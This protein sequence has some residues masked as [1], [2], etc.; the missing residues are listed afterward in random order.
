MRFVPVALADRPS[1]ARRGHPVH[2]RRHFIDLHGP[3][4]WQSLLHGHHVE[5][6][7]IEVAIPACRVVLD[8]LPLQRRSSHRRRRFEL[9]LRFQLH[10]IREAR[11]QEVGPRVRIVLDEHPARTSH[12]LH[13]HLIGVL[14]G[15]DPRD[16]R[17]E[18]FLGV[19]ATPLVHQANGT[20]D[21]EWMTNG[22]SFKARTGMVAVCATIP[23]F[24]GVD[25]SSQA[26]ERT[27]P[28][29]PSLGAAEVELRRQRCARCKR[30]RSALVP[31]PPVQAVVHAAAGQ[32]APIRGADHE[33]SA[34]VL[35]G[36]AAN[37]Q[38][39]CVVGVGQKAI[40]PARVS[41]PH[42]GSSNNYLV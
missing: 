13:R 29:T 18:L 38:L 10:P 6:P 40:P 39:G 17:I 4:R 23:T 1:S 2:A 24:V 9:S 42:T 5:H 27:R 28:L 22:A 8:R 25:A 21:Q 7:V 14:R 36:P 41:H 19:W 12:D 32:D 15:R 37:D 31:L 26:A 33:P 11:P 30:R 16:E 35:V 34:S 20:D 3:A